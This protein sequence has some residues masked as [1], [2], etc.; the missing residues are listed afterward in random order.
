MTL[1][2]TPWDDRKT[3]SNKGKR[4]NTKLLYKIILPPIT[5]T[6]DMLNRPVSDKITSDQIP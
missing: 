6:S 2:P 5:V 3:Q 1:S 4:Q